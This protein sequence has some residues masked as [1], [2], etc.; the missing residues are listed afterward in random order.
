MWKLVWMMLKFTLLM[1]VWAVKEKMQQ[2]IHLI[3]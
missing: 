2:M 3:P 1:K